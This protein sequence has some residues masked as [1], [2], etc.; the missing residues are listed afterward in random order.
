MLVPLNDTP[1]PIPSP[2]GGG[3]IPAALIP[4]TSIVVSADI[5]IFPRDGTLRGELG[6][7]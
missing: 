2:Q 5:F 4:I 7:A 1:T 3:G 6:P